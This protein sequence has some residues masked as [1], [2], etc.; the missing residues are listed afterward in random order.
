MAYYGSPSPQSTG[1]SGENGSRAMAAKLPSPDGR[2]SRRNAYAAI[3]LGTNNCRLLIAKP[4]A[5]GFLVVDAFSRIVRLG[6]G[7]A[8]GSE[9]RSAGKGWVRTVS[10]LGSS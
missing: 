6:V 8:T 4:P 10:N 2:G 1:A 5:E 3:D 7:L 9:A